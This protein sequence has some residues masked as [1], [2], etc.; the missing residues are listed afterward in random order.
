MIRKGSP[1][2]ATHT[3]WGR[4]MHAVKSIGDKNIATPVPAGIVRNQVKVARVVC[5]TGAERSA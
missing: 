5:H 3:F 4:Y 2:L 1:Q